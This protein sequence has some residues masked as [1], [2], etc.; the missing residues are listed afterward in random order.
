MQIK[1]NVYV[2]VFRAPYRTP[3]YRTPP[4]AQ[5]VQNVPLPRDA[6]RGALLQTP[7]LIAPHIAAAVV[8][9]EGGGGVG[10]QD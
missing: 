2:R 4:Y 6:E 9:Q 7:L 8:E 5:I 3:P 1:N 10:K